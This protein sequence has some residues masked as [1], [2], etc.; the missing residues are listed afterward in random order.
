[1]GFLQRLKNKFLFMSSAQAL[2]GSFF[3]ILLLVL[4]LMITGNIVRV[5]INA[6]SN[7]EIY[8]EEKKGF[9]SLLAT[10]NKLLEERE[11]LSN[12]E[13][14]MLLLREIDSLAKE[15]QLLFTTREKPVYFKEKFI[16]FSIDEK[17]NYEDWW[18]KLIK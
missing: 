4:F 3:S 6:V 16:P 8:L 1:M 15:N 7:Y 18:F 12:D 17:N 5:V 13:S 10:Y 11:Y 14:R 2:Q 9:E